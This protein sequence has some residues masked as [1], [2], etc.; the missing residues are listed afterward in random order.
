MPFA[1]S[2]DEF[3]SMQEHDE[4]PPPPEMLSAFRK[5]LT[6]PS[7]H[8]SAIAKE[9]AA[10]IIANMPNEQD[11][12]WP[13]CTLLWRTLARAVDTFAASN[14]RF[15]DFVVQLQ[16]LPDGDGVFEMLP[17]FNNHW[18]E[19]G[20]TMTY[21]VSDEPE[22]NLKHQAQTN[23]HAF[24][25]KLSTYK[26]IPVLDQIH[27]AGFTFRSTCEFA[28]WERVHFPE[29]EEW[30][31]PHDDP[32]EFD[33]P[34]RRDL[35]LER[36][37]IKMLNAKVPAAAQWLRHV[38]QRIYDMQGDMDGEH[39][40]QTK[41]LNPKWKGPKG[42]SKQR[43]SFWRERFEWMAQVTALDKDTQKIAL[44]CAQEMKKIEEAA[45]V[46]QIQCEKSN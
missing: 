46:Y 28:P 23:Q 16:K 4:Y 36:V 43:F 44:E 32:A 12:R 31:D 39:D 42:Y 18:T 27:R 38:G 8:T 11:P 45:H 13:D 40:W 3:L 17:Q 34:A 15:V 41:V 22:R 10:P 24:C 9:A 14:D 26:H 35:E 33:W 2:H 20:Y 7:I 29:I 25:A 5:L 6:A 1:T 21:Y 37:N 30:Y 19:F